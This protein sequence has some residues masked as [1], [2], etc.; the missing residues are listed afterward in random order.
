MSLAMAQVMIANFP[1]LRQN[2]RT[3]LVVIL[4]QDSHLEIQTWVGVRVVRVPL[5]VIVLT[6]PLCKV[7]SCIG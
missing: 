5:S 1:G 2:T 3:I 6:G 7:I 4:H